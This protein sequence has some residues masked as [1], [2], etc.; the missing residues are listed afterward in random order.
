M[1][2]GQKRI[3]AAARCRNSANMALHFRRRLRGGRNRGHPIGRNAISPVPE[4][5]HCAFDPMCD[6]NFI[7]LHPAA[8]SGRR[9]ISVDLA[10][11]AFVEP[12]L[13]G[14]RERLILT[15]RFV[16]IWGE[17]HDD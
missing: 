11:I 14:L 4:V 16:S 5:P 6:N 3:R 13:A 1:A 2:E 9:N 7:L 10:R 12:P 8:I 15:Y 17:H